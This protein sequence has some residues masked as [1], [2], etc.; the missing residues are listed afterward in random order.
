M[1]AVRI[2]WHGVMQPHLCMNF[3]PELPESGNPLKPY[4]SR[5]TCTITLGACLRPGVHEAVTLVGQAAVAPGT[6]SAQ[7]KETLGHSG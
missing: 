6:L 2:P 5:T 4:V 3:H 1:H 7:E